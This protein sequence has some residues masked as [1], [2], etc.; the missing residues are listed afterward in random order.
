MSVRDAKRV[1]GKGQNQM[2]Q[3]KHAYKSSRKEASIKIQSHKNKAKIQKAL[4]PKN[5]EKGWKLEHKVQRRTDKEGGDH[6]D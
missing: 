1:K 4:R 2:R 3:S 6:T 5:E